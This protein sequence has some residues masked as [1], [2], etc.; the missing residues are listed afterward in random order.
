M[1]FVAITAANA[2]GSGRIG[3]SLDSD[4]MELAA[5]GAIREAIG[6]KSQPIAINGPHQWPLLRSSGEQWARG[7]AIAI[8]GS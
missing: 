7:A 1:A 6:G 3:Q 4:R 5:I 2:N 8:E